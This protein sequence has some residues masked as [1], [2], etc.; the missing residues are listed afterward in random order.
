VAGLATA[1]GSGAMTN[2]MADIAQGARCILAI[3]TDTGANH[4]VFG[5]RVKGAARHGAKLIVANP[6]EIDL[7]EFATLW[8][9]HRP[10]TDVALLSGMARVILDEGLA[11]RHFIEE[12]CEDFEAFGESLKAYD[13]G[14]VSELTGVPAEDI[15]AAARVY[16]T[17]RPAA[18][19][20]AMGITQHSHGT[21]N[22]Q[23]V[24]NLA[25][26]TGNIGQPGAGV[27]PLRGQNNVQGACDMGCLPN[28]LPGYQSVAD[29]SLRQAF[30]S[31][32]GVAL[33]PRPGLTLLEIFNAAYE[34]KVKALYLVGENP[35][36][37]DPDAHHVA[38]ALKRLDFLVV[39][40]IFLTETAELAQVVLPATTFAEKEG[41]FTNTE[42]RVQRVRQVIPPIGQS[43]PDWLIT[44]QIAGKM[45]GQGF[46]YTHPSQIM[47]EISRLTPSYRG[48]SHQRLEKGGLPW[49][50]PTPDH[51][52]TPLLHV[53]KFTRGKGRF[54]PVE[55]R[56]SAELPDEEY[57]LML[58]TGR[59]P[60][61]YHTGTM[62][63]KVKGLNLLRGEELVELN[64]VDAA[65]LGISDGDRVK[66]TSRR[67]E[68]QAKAKV[69]EVSP[70]GLVSMTWHFA[71]SPTNLLTNPALDP[72]A[73]IPELKVAAVRVEK[74]AQA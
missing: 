44:C 42:R 36:L 22:V 25:M 33:P 27:N 62:T 21:D 3:G 28:V 12:R 11:D 2:S 46:D 67:G 69:T 60:F 37:S 61:Q 71:E 6:R 14:R 20:Y 19:L 64:P 29:A 53:D 38:E 10:G 40:D 51:P 43:R 17:E 73:K 55:F 23:A 52:G 41:T 5:M 66:V 39:Q 68:V 15:A 8:L 65:E 34:G 16:A 35:V 49:P 7:C 57:P 31:A 9:R 50:C 30:E 63:R 59:S 54:T 48:L 56:P 4:P 47:E 24:A 74:V 13:L 26:L 70:P 1:F 32:W 72:V 18:I 45:G 58:T